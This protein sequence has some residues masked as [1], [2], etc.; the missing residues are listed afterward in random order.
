MLRGTE[1]SDR[2]FT[3]GMEAVGSTPEQTATTIRAE[4]AK[5]GRVIREAGIRE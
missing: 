1:I 5:W 3:L 2:M 4:I